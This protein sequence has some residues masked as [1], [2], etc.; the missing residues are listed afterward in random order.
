MPVHMVYK[1][2]HHTYLDLHGARSQSSDFLLHP[3]CNTWVHC[4]A[5]RQH[6][7]GIKILPDVYV[8]FHDAVVSGFMNAS[9]LHA[10]GRCRRTLRNQL[11]TET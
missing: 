9:R 10:W 1:R 3:V 5:S 11:H 7:V 4:G 2:F 8:T 6:V